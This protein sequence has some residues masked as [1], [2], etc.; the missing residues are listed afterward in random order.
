MKVRYIQSSEHF[1]ITKGK[2]Y[3]VIDQRC[4]GYYQI[5]NNE[6]DKENYKKE[7]FELIY[8]IEEI[9]NGKFAVEIDNESNWKKCNSVFGFT[10]KYYPKQ[11]YYGKGGFASLDY[12]KKNNYTII[13]FNQIEFMEEFVL[14]ETWFIKSTPE[15]YEV[16]KKWLIE[17]DHSGSNWCFYSSNDNRYLT[18]RFTHSEDCD[19]LISKGGSEITFEQFKKHVLKE[20]NMSN[21]TIIGYKL[22]KPE[23]REAVFSISNL[24]NIETFE[25][26]KSLECS[27]NIEGYDKA[28]VKLQNA[29]VFNLWF[30]P[31][32]KKEEEY[33]VGDYIT[34]TKERKGFN[35]ELG[36]T[37]KILKLNGYLLIYADGYS[38]S[39]KEVGIRLAI[40]EEIEAAQQIEL[41]IGDKFTKVII[42]KNKILAENKEIAIEGLKNILEDFKPNRYPGIPW[43]I[44]FIDCVKIGCSVFDKKDLEQVVDIYNSLQ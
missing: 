11:K 21:K 23:Y 17:N 27:S 22:I 6:G 20:N 16:I 24:A 40:P 5:I 31:I 14:P 43:D 13:K 10:T 42:T 44:N 18:Y 25:H 19:Y 4:N 1:S 29:K 8:S 35:G 9:K 2:I 36:K 3:D 32:Y 12:F 26:Y 37:Y 39:K 30:E 33:K 34:V 28:I 15:N 41:T 7:R 38:I